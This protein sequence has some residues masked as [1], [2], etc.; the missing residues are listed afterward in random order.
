MPTPEDLKNL[1]AEL[2]RRADAALAAKDVDA[3]VELTRKAIALESAAAEMERLTVPYL[4]TRT[5]EEMTRAQAQLQRRSRAIAAATATGP[6]HEAMD[7]D[8]RFG[9][10]RKWCLKRGEKRSNMSAWINGKWPM[11]RVVYNKLRHDFPRLDWTPPR[12]L[13]D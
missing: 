6:V 1:A 7:K 5:V 4:S 12:G 3:V 8:P 9:S 2:S 11:P 13:A 10:L